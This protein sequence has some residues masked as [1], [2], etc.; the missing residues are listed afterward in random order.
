MQIIIK[1]KAE[2]PVS[3]PIV[4]GEP[5][6]PTGGRLLDGRCRAIIENHPNAIVA[7][8][9][10]AS[11]AYYIHDMPILSDGFYDEL[12]KTM[13]DRW[14]DIEHQHKHLI[15][16]ENLKAGSLFNLS[17]EQYPSI[18]KGAASRLIKSAWGVTIPLV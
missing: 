3:E 16:E 6:K 5:P 10:I 15:T 17:A 9:L 1:K 4:D 11:Y 12:A 13:L 18:T 7:W 14:S 2:A 8:W